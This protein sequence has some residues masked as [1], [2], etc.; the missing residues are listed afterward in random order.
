MEFILYL[1]YIQRKSLSSANEDDRDIVVQ[2]YNSCKRLL[3]RAQTGEA[4]KG[5]RGEKWRSFF[6]F[7]CTAYKI[8]YTGFGIFY[9]SGK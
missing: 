5:Q 1:L 4:T 3:S 6:S 9:L 8:S 2:V 7:S